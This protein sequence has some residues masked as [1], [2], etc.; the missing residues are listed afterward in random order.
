MERE[1]NLYCIQPPGSNQVLVSPLSDSDAHFASILTQLTI[2]G[3]KNIPLF[4]KNI[5]KDVIQKNIITLQYH[6][7]LMFSESSLNH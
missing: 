7:I 3:S 1:W 5:I 2:F 4:K 6:V